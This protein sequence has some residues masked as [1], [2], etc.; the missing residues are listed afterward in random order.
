MS[1]IQN[2]ICNE[3]ILLQLKIKVSEGKGE[4]MKYLRLIKYFVLIGLCIIAVI[5]LRNTFFYKTPSLNTNIITG[6]SEKCGR[7]NISVDPRLELLAS[8]ELNSDFYNIVDYE[9]EYKNDMRSYFRKFKNHRAIKMF[10][11]LSKDGI[12]VDIP[13]HFMI[14]LSEVPEL[15]VKYKIDEEIISLFT[16]DQETTALFLEE[17]RNYAAQSNFKEFFINHYDFY[18]EKINDAKKILSNHD[19]VKDIEEYYGFEQN[20][21]NIIL[22]PLFEGNYGLKFPAEDNKFDLFAVIGGS[23]FADN[24]E[25]VLRYLIWHEFSHSFI[26]PITDKYADTIKESESNFELIKDDM[27]K[28]GYDSWRIAINEHI[29]RAVTIRLTEIVYGKDAAEILLDKEKANGFIYLDNLC[30]RLIYYENHR[31][32]YS[33]IESYYPYLLEV[34]SEEPSKTVN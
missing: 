10:R 1:G 12:Y 19:Y 33:S 4:N 26:N 8:V 25:E 2:A 34:F 17:L 15:K 5:I 14:H 20:S 32:E 31:N 13:P 23:D 27:K 24:S 6:I 30:S 3:N 16:K 22:S 28:Q 9:T 7:I 21:Y 29:I 11:Q 18:Q